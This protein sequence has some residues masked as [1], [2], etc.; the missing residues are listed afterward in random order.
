MAMAQDQMLVGQQQGAVQHQ[1]PSLGMTWMSCRN[2]LTCSRA[3]AEHVLGLP[4]TCTWTVS[5]KA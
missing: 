5:Q 2:A 1:Q 3:A 4:H